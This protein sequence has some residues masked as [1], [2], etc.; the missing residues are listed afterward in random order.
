MPRSLTTTVR[1]QDIVN[2]IVKNM[3]LTKKEA[4]HYNQMSLEKFRIMKARTNAFAEYVIREGAVLKPG[5]KFKRLDVLK[6]IQDMMKAPTVK[7]FFK[8]LRRYYKTVVGVPGG[9]GIDGL[10]PTSGGDPQKNVW[11]KM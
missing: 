1:R 5:K 6:D 3:G 10:R 8:A 9:N 7:E 4:S 11:K 2:W